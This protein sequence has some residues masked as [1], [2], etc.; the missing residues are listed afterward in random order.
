MPLIRNVLPSMLNQRLLWSQL[1]TFWWEGR[2]Y[3]AAK[4]AATLGNWALA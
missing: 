3:V 1:W 4:V 2:V